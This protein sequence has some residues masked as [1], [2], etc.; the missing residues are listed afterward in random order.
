MCMSIIICPRFSLTPTNFSSTLAARGNQGINKVTLIFVQS[1]WTPCFMGRREYLLSYSCFLE[2]EKLF[3]DANRILFKKLMYVSILFWIVQNYS[4][5]LF[6]ICGY[7]SN[8]FVCF[9]IHMANNYNYLFVYN[10]YIHNSLQDF[11][12][13]HS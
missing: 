3:N 11:L 8:M 12:G 13:I 1:L 5:K 4:L 7:S 9:F 2:P 6:S 10:N